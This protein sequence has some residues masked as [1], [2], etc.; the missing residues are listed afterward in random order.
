MGSVVGLRVAPDRSLWLHVDGVCQGRVAASV[1]THYHAVYLLDSYNV[2][3]VETFL[4]LSRSLNLPQLSSS[5]ALSTNAEVKQVGTLLQLG[6][7]VN[8]LTYT[9]QLLASQASATPCVS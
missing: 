6:W 5:T 9:S 8:F 7:L 2:H 3:E 4:Q 1:P